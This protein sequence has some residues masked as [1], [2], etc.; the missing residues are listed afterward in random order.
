MAGRMNSGAAGGGGPAASGSQ[1][2]ADQMGPPNVNQDQRSVNR[3]GSGYI[4]GSVPGL[5][6]LLQSV[7]N[8]VVYG[9]NVLLNSVLPT[10]NGTPDYTAMGVLDTRYLP[11]VVTNG[12]RAS[13]GRHNGEFIFDLRVM[14][15]GYLAGVLE[16]AI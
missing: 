3:G 9:H 13:V 2:S 8:Q 10:I 16:Q 11:T 15:L 7:T 12:P 14:G 1:D 6:Q 4:Q 5:Y